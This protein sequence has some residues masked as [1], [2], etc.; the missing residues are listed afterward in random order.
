LIISFDVG[1]GVG[2]GGELGVLERE[3]ATATVTIATATRFTWLAFSSYSMASTRVC[4]LLDVEERVRGCAPKRIER[5]DASLMSFVYVH[6]DVNESLDALLGRLGGFKGIEWM[7]HERQIR[8]S[9]EHANERNERESLPDEENG[10]KEFMPSRVYW[11]VHTGG[12]FVR[13]CV[14]V[15]WKTNDWLDGNII[16]VGVAVFFYLFGK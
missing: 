14:C 3:K 12:L 10:T 13:V 1:R 9:N 2:W 15:H 11:C 7:S 8:N 4:V 5:V 6:R 16:E